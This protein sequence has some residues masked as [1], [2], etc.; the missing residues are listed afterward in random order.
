MLYCLAKSK[1]FNMKKV[2]STKKITFSFIENFSWYDKIEIVPCKYGLNKPSWSPLIDILVRNPP[3][4]H[5]FIE[6]TRSMHAHLC[7]HTPCNVRFGLTNIDQQL[8]FQVTPQSLN[9]RGDLKHHKLFANVWCSQCDAE[10]TTIML[11]NSAY[12]T[13]NQSP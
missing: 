10:L 4:N 1:C 7:W 3:W 11:H 2:P 8:Q 12:H 5:T 13:T 9:T 6:N